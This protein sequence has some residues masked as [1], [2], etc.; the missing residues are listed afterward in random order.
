MAS[1]SST[2]N[3]MDYPEEVSPMAPPPQERL[4]TPLRIALLTNFVPPYRIPVFREIAG[5]VASFR[6]LVSTLMEANRHWAVDFGGLEVVVQRNLTLRRRWRHPSGFEETMYLH[7]PWDTL[8]QLL[9]YRPDVVVSGEFGFRTLNAVIYKLL[10]RS[11]LVIWATISESS[12]AKREKIRLFLRAFMLRLADAVVTNGTSGARYLAGHGANPDKIFVVPQTT[13]IRAFA[14]APLERAPQACRTLIYAGQLVPRKGLLPFL[15]SLAGWCV[16]HPD[17]RVEFHLC[18]DGSE[19]TAIE[20]LSLPPNLF[21]RLLGNASYAEM[22]AR[23]A[24][25]GVMVLPT[26]ADEW[27]LV[28]NEALASGLP[29]LGSVYSSAVEDLVEDGV[30]GWQFRV[31]DPEEMYRAI[32]RCLLTPECALSEMRVRAREASLRISPEYVVDRM[33]AA[34]LYARSGRR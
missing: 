34:V 25:A 5:R 9:R 24:A 26:F 10:S 27:G 18:G 28:V 21:L 14:D 31:D 29:V 20:A 17:E 12:E 13:D 2:R 16:D 15:Q 30:N 7:F 23:Y 4:P 1:R 19:R 6:V 32:D 33:M 3:P 22:P 8:W 11:K